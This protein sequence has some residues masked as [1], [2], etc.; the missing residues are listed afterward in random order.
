MP[1][2]TASLLCNLDAFISFIYW[3]LNFP[4]RMFFFVINP[5]DVQPH[6][7]LRLI[8]RFVYSN[9]FRDVETAVLFRNVIM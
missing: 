7:L 8:C 3:A 5:P 2:T 4:R 1:L 6:D 9:N